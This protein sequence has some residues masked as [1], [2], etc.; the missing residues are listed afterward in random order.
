MNEIQEYANAIV[1]TAKTFEYDELYDVNE[2]SGPC[3]VCGR[4]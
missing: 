1:E 3:P 4:P 2:P